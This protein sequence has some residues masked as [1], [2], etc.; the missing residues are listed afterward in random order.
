MLSWMGK[1][2]LEILFAIVF[3]LANL[4]QTLLFGTATQTG[5]PFV[6]STSGVIGED[7]SIVNLIGDLLIAVFV[8]VG[9]A[10]YRS[11]LR[12]WENTNNYR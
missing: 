12:S 3:V 2:W 5:F 11:N 9:T 8:I 6:F 4:P 10:F 1:Y 7:F